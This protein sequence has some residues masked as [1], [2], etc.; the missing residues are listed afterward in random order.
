MLV[1]KAIVMTPMKGGC[2]F[3]KN[4]TFSGRSL[5]ALKDFIFGIF[6]TLDRRKKK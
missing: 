1:H 6:V 4:L 2:H 5:I 3:Q